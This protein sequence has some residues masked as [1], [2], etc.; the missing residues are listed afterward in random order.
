M[1]MVLW[2]AELVDVCGAFLYGQFGKEK[3]MEMSPGF[4]KY[5]PCNV[6]LLLL[7]TLYALKQVAYAFW[8][9]AIL[10]DEICG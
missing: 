9:K 7:N 8:L 5:Y 2:C 10:F 1:I 6:V 4:K 3:K